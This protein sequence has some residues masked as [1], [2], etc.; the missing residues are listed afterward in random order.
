MITTFTS[1]L[2]F[3]EVRNMRFTNFGPNFQNNFFPRGNLDSLGKNDPENRKNND[4]TNFPAENQRFFTFRTLPKLARNTR[5]KNFGRKSQNHV[6]PRGNLVF[7]SKNDPGKWKNNGLAQFPAE[8][9]RFFVFSKNWSHTQRTRHTKRS[10]SHLRTCLSVYVW[11]FD[12]WKLIFPNY[13]TIW[14]GGTMSGKICPSHLHSKTGLWSCSLLQ[15][16][17][18]R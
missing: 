1:V 15:V 17:S 12:V 9:R 7:L 11:G 13:E 18:A 4:L 14:L 3:G 2:V 10:A 8:N 16:N 5:I 6:F